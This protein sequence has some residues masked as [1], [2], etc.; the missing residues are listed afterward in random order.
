MFALGAGIDKSLNLSVFLDLILDAS[1]NHNGLQKEVP[2][3]LPKTGFSVIIDRLGG[4]LFEIACYR[5]IIGRR[6]P[7]RT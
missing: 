3:D 6:N 1:N 5:V 2:D 7:W 4:M